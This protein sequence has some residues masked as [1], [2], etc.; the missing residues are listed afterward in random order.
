MPEGG[1]P[2]AQDQRSLAKAEELKKAE[3]ILSPDQQKS[4]DEAGADSG[5][6]AGGAGGAAGG[7]ASMMASM[8]G[9]GGKRGEMMGSMGMGSAI[10]V[11][12]RDDEEE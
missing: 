3:D 5:G 2:E 1:N 10:D 9:G 4:A 7:M 6:G 11:E 8:G 12:Q